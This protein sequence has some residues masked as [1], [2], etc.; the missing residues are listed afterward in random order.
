MTADDLARLMSLLS[1]ELRSPVG[2]IRGYLRILDQGELTD[3]QRIV[4]TAALRA[5]DRAAE[6]LAEASLL[7]HLHVGDI[8]LDRK[9]VALIPLL[10]QAVQAVDLPE[11]SPVAL[12][13]LTTMSVQVLADEPRLR[14]ALVSV[15]TA[16]ARAQ[17]STVTVEITATKTQLQRR[18]TIRLRIGPRTLTRVK[19]RETPPDLTRGGMGLS[20]PIAVAVIEAHRGKIRELRHGASSTAVVVWLPVT[21]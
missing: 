11:E 16:V 13:V 15:I 6:L 20:L 17:T 12:D 18:P 5:G 7:G 4:V 3:A 8:V 2:V 21:R 10:H 9:R 14:A 19:A 1:H